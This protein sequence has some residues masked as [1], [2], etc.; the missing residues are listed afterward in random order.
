MPLCG[1]WSREEQNQYVE[2]ITGPTDG[3]PTP[4]SGPAHLPT[5]AQPRA[6]FAMR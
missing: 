5:A 4:P 1:R 6:G 2:V 3:E